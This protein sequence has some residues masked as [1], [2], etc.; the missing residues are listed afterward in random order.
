VDEPRNTS[1]AEKQGTALWL[2]RLAPL[3]ALA[4]LVV[5]VVI[6]RGAVFHSD[7]VFNPDESEMLAAGRRAAL[8]IQPYGTYTSPTFL[9]LWPLLLGVLSSI[10]FSLT[11]SLA[12]ILSGIAYVWIAFVVWFGVARY[13]GWR[14]SA[15]LVLPTSLYLFAGIPAPNLVDGD[16]GFPDFLSLGTELLPISLLMASCCVIVTGRG[17]PGHWRLLLAS[18]IAGMAMWAKPQTVIVAGSFVVAALLLRYIL[19]E[20]S[21]GKEGAKATAKDAAIA[22]GGFFVPSVLFFIWMVAGDTL[23]YF[24]QEPARVNWTYITARDTLPGGAALTIWQRFEPLGNFVLGYPL[25]IVWALAGLVGFTAIRTKRV[26]S[27]TTATAVLW[28]TPL[29][30]ATATLALSFPLFPHYANL[31]YGGGAIA[32]VLGARVAIAADPMRRH[33]AAAWAPLALIGTLAALAA[34]SATGGAIYRNLD[35]IREHPATFTGGTSDPL[36]KACPRGSRV[37]FWGYGLEFYAAY[38]WVPASRYVNIGW[39]LIDSKR[40]NVYQD[41]FVG[42]IRS[43]PPQCI[44]EALDPKFASPGWTDADNLKARVPE[45][46]PLLKRCYASREITIPDGRPVRLYVWNDRCAA[47]LS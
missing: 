24:I 39:I 41:R 46:A 20:R 3:I 6:C 30:A 36:E 16:L 19:T 32:A 47:P 45:L 9:F 17:V 12:H 14:R 13:M 26:R 29:V 10:G 18:A 34:I 37:L 23:Q 38:D 15:L 21:W 8:G 1:T 7:A 25:A 5:L 44:V 11:L 35:T 2:A 22:C 42:E 33:V 4:V 28:L 40:Q 27:M 43:A 31:L